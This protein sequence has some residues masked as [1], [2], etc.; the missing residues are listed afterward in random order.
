M[1]KQKKQVTNPQIKPSSAV[2]ISQNPLNWWLILPAIVMLFTYTKIVLDPVLITKYLLFLLLLLAG[3]IVVWRTTLSTDF[4]SLLRSPSYFFILYGIYILFS[5]LSIL[6]ATL[7]GD[8]LFEWSKPVLFLW[9][10]LLLLFYYKNNKTADYQVDI[11]RILSIF[12]LM[13]CVVGLIQGVLLLQEKQINHE[14]LY[15]ISSLFSHRN[16]FCEV[17]LL[18]L[19]FT[20]YASMYEK[21][22]I[23]KI[24][25]SATI[26]SLVFLIGLLSRSIWIAMILALIIVGVSYI[27]MEIPNWKKEA[28]SAYMFQTLSKYIGGFLLLFVL[29]ML[30]FSYLDKSNPVQKLVNSITNV[31]YY[32]NQDRLQKWQHSISIFKEN[33]ILGTGLG[34][35]KI[36]IMAFPAH[37]TECEYGKL[38]FQRPHNDYLWV[39]S[40]SG[41][42]AF[43]AYLGI[44]ISILFVGYKNIR[45]SNS[46]S[47][48]NWLYLM[49][50]GIVAYV[51][52]STF[53]FPK[54]RM[55]D[56][57]LLH[58][59]FAGILIG[60][61][62]QGESA[63]SSY[64]KPLL[65]IG[66]IVLIFCL[67]L[68]KERFLGEK[69]MR[70]YQNAK[71]QGKA[72]ATIKAG[73]KSLRP[74]YQMDPVSTPVEYLI[75]SEYLP[76]SKTQM[77]KEHL[78]AAYAITPNHVQVLN[79][80]GACYFQLN[81]KAKAEELYKR[82]IYLAP[83]YQDALLS[84]AVVQLQKRTIAGYWDAFEAVCGVDSSSKDAKYAS[85]FSQLGDTLISHL[86]Y[87]EPILQ[88]EMQ[89][90]IKNKSAAILAFQHRKG[91]KLPFS[92]QMMAEVLY[93]MYVNKAIT[94]EEWTT[95]KKK[96]KCEIQTSKK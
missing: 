60:N 26:L 71:G 54:E 20:I 79:N 33:P 21:T 51:V 9:S 82:A 44:F 19:P 67:Y 55:E 78:D 59:L 89:K 85:Y 48:R 76:I 10:L 4:F 46:E 62:K 58:L 84:L 2:S 13:S 75:G 57:Y 22:S 53:A 11:S 68:G 52:F 56:M 30:I 74:F 3:T 29:I 94:E 38:L 61:N 93:K 36:D 5:G 16:I 27:I 37:D 86:Q 1:A 7:L 35:W 23:R 39:L 64:S 91:S 42:I 88:S 8:A 43:L 47:E 49:L 6:N 77:A 18:L 25:I 70:E 92:I 40:E 24:A 83:K 31:N 95:L 41:I 65:G 45:A 73:E 80:L 17:L 50:Y 81:D 87:D 69:Y 34:D 28:K 66:L 72:D 15:A 12:S 63:I 90:A 96:Y 14:N 32:S